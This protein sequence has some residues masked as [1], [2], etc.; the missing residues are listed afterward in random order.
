ML[1][2]DDLPYL[3]K[4]PRTRHEAFM[5]LSENVGL[6]GDP[7]LSRIKKVHIQ[8]MSSMYLSGTLLTVK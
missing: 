6:E 8:I 5:H 4:D 3:G 2:N 7:E 1:Q